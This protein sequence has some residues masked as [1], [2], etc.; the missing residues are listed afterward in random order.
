[1]MA[2][3]LNKKGLVIVMTAEADF[4]K[5]QR[6]ADK[7]LIAKIV[8]CVGFKQINS[9]Y[10]WEG[11]IE[12][13]NEVQLLIKTNRIKLNEVLELIKEFHSYH[14]PELLYWNVSSSGPYSEWVNEVISS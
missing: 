1:M 12:K 11:K 3:L 14:V 9:N 5:A 4:E 10:W 7:L 6:L 13:N 2:F 8:S